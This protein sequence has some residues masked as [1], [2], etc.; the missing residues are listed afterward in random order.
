MHK[1]FELAHTRRMVKIQNKLEKAVG[2][3]EYFTTNQWRFSDD[4]VQELLTHMSVSDRSTFPFDVTQIDWDAYF[5]RYVLGLRAFLCK[6][7][8]KTLPSCRKKMTRYALHTQD[9]SK[10]HKTRQL[11]MPFVFHFRLYVVH[12][13]SKILLVIFTW[14]FMMARSKKIRDTWSGI[15]R[16]ILQTLSLLPFF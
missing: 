12:Q 14:R 7:N 3:L 1:H 8:P 11:I 6:Q 4:N 2:C 5:E 13:M 16:I 9:K 15:L 10:P